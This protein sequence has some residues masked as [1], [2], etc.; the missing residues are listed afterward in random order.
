ME[1]KRNYMKK[2]I[3][4]NTIIVLLIINLLIGVINTITNIE[5]SNDIE[6]NER[7]Y[8]VFLDNQY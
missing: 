1:P 5:Q 4:T 3:R 2:R 7:L 6:F 8:D